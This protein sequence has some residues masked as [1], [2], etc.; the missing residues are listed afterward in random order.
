MLVKLISALL[1][2][3]QILLFVDLL[4][5]WFPVDHNSR[6]VRRMHAIT[7]PLLMPFRALLDRVQFLRNIPFDFSYLAAFLVLELILQLIV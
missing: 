5:E 3:L 6:S 7:V 1:R 2:I 4:L